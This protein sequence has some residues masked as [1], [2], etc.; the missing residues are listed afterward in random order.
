VAEALSADAAAASMVNDE[1]AEAVSPAPL[2]KAPASLPRVSVVVPCK[3][4][5]HWL[6]ATLDS[7]L[8]QD[9]PNL[10]VIVV[11]G[12]SNDGTQALLESYEAR[13]V[14]W[15]SGPDAGPFD[16]INK[17]WELAT[18][19][20]LAWLNAD[21]TYEPG[22]VAK[23]VEYLQEH[24]EAAVVYGACGM[25]DPRGHF[26]GI[27]P[28]RP[29]D[30]EHAVYHCDHILMQCTTFMRRSAVEAVGGVYPSWAHDQEL[31]LR[32]ALAGGE[33]HPIED[34]L[35]NVRLGEDHTHNRPEVMI[36][37]RLE[38]MERLFATPGLPPRLRQIHARALSNTY[39]RGFDVLRP[40]RA[41]H[42]KW[43]YICLRGA[44]REDPSNTPH[45]LAGI[46]DRALNRYRFVRPVARRAW[47]SLRPAKLVLVTLAIVFALRLTARDRGA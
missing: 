39:L 12:G 34:H 9:Y 8:A 23:A 47:S 28:P 41:S 22:A 2:A 32:I 29:W 40:R 25:I 17:G 7:I 15:T 37:A 13:G 16:A 45:V 1:V 14:T 35:A 11:D 4:R 10:E 33:L 5:A 43:A 31:W 30:I 26:V 24:P 46:L 27:M 20:I 18:G 44:I 42:W 36:P 19:D 38:M 3:D 6:P 21:D